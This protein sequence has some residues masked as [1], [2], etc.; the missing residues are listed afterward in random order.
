MAVLSPFLGALSDVRE[1]KKRFLFFFAAIGILSTASLYFVS[2]GQWMLAAIL[3][4][5][6]IL[7]FNGS[8]TFYDSLLPSIAPP[9]KQ[10]YA[11]SLGFSLGYLGGGVLFALN[12]YMTLNP[13]FFGLP[14]LVGAVQTSFL[15]VATW[16]FLFSLPLFFFV[17]E[18]KV[19]SQERLPLS[20]AFKKA[21]TNLIHI[22]KEIKSQ[23]HLFYFLI[24]FWFYID[25]VNTVMSMAV[26]FGLNIGL[27]QTALIKALLLVQFIGFP[28]AL[29]VYKL[30]NRIGTKQAIMI[31]IAVYFLTVILA[32]QMKTEMH[33]YALAVVI[34]MVQGGI[35]ALSRSLYSRMIPQDK[36]GEYFGFYNLIGR[37]ASIV[38]PLLVGAGA[39]VFQD[40]GLT[41]LPLLVLFV[42]GAF[43][44]NKVQFQ[45]VK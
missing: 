7:G 45:A 15:M 9:E 8:L 4:G 39:L 18:P 21:I 42:A 17:P 30:A 31:C 27:E 11:S 24:G 6:A 16:W 37:F 38:G 3:Y 41:L 12:V 26:N 10:D 43:F 29:L 23:P 32:S 19:S 20:V 36:A 22:F 35:Q 44:L 28:F 40:Q 1:S 2:Q 34:G 33:F 25:G 5:F 14:H 13:G